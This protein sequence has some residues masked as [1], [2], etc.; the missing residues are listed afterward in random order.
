MRVQFVSK[1]LDKILSQRPNTTMTRSE[2]IYPEP[3]A[4]LCPDLTSDFRSAASNRVIHT[5]PPRSGQ[6]LPSIR[7]IHPRLGNAGRNNKTFRFLFL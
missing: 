7:T 1:N 2:V 5:A 6:A 4:G 3:S